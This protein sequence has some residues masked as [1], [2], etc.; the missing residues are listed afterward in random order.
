MALSHH[1]SQQRKKVT[2]VVSSWTTW[3]T[4]TTFCMTTPVSY[5]LQETDTW[6]TSAM[7][8]PGYFVYGTDHGRT[9]ILCPREVND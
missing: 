2:G 1:Q 5:A 4:N 6:T 3:D 9:A 7:N 8:V